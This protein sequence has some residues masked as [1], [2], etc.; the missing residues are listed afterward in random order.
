MFGSSGITWIHG[1]YMSCSELIEAFLAAK[2]H[3]FASHTLRA[4]RHDLTRFAQLHPDIFIHKITESHLR[5]YLDATD[6][7]KPNTK[8]RRKATLHSCFSWAYKQ[9]L[10]PS[11]P[12]A[13][14]EAVPFEV[15][16]PRP[17]T[18]KQV[19]A[20]LNVIP[21]Q[22]LRNRLLLTLLFE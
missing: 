9:G 14:L 11:D 13:I 22:E 1:G 6:D 19:E 20:I 12:T 8:A 4:Y 10:V 5:L 18:E 3:T 16:V 17:L 21:Q 2:Q 15:R 7:Q